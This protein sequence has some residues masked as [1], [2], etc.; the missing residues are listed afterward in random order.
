MSC[1]VA[2][3][4]HIERTVEHWLPRIEEAFQTAQAPILLARLG[5]SAPAQGEAEWR[6]W[7]VE[8]LNA[9]ECRNAALQARQDAWW[10]EFKASALRVGGV[11]VSTVLYALMLV[12][13]GA[14]FIITMTLADFAIDYLGG[15]ESAFIAIIGTALEETG[16]V[17]L[18]MHVGL[19]MFSMAPRIWT[20]ELLPAITRAQNYAEHLRTGAARLESRENQLH[21]IE[22]L[23]SFQQLQESMLSGSEDASGSEGDEG[24]DINLQT[25]EA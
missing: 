8:N 3:P 7:N 21:L 24:D 5:L 2:I 20:K 17:L 11:F 14:V 18:T 19:R 6:V 25:V 1:F 22:H 10:E 16:L 23:R 9:E 13:A 12:V 4:R 15:I